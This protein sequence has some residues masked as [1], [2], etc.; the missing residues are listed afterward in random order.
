MN[1]PLHYEF[2]CL[3]QKGYNQ[4]DKKT[5]LAQK[6]TIPMDKKKEILLLTKYIKSANLLKQKGGYKTYRLIYL[7]KSPSCLWR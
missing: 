1:R 2:S 6:R 3:L 5:L 7:G 4:K